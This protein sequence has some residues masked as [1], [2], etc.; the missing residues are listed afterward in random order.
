MAKKAA[1]KEA[2][3]EPNKAQ[4]IRDFFTVNPGAKGTEVVAALAARGIT[5]AP[6]QVSNV[7]TAMGMGGKRKAKDTK[8]PKINLGKP[9]K[10]KAAVVGMS[11]AQLV[12]WGRNLIEHCGGVDEAQAFLT[13]LGK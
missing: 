12:G 11:P 7:K 4:A 1:A 3:K 13:A 5:V 6:A 2:G 8:L 9:A 10:V